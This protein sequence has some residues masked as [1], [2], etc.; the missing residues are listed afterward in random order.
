MQTRE[1]LTCTLYNMD[2]M[3]FM[4]Q[5]PDECFDL[6]VTSPP[7][8]SLRPEYSFWDTYEEYIDQLDEWFAESVRL[9]PAGRHSVWNVQQAIPSKLNGERY[10]YPLSADLIQ[11]AYR[12][13]MWLEHTVVWNKINAVCQRMFGSYPYPPTIIYTPNIEDIHIFKKPGKADLSRKTDESLITKEEWTEWALPIWNMPIS[14]NKKH[15]AT[16]PLELPKRVIRL[17]SFVG[18]TV[19]D[20]FAGLGTTG[21]ACKLLDRNFVGTE[22]KE[23]YYK[24]A[25]DNINGVQPRL[26]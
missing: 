21:V 22:L 19:F 26:L 17:H 18:D 3:E 9:I 25:R 7:Y 5:Q 2:C 13:G 20:P 12:H 1:G 23:E 15:A 14:Y 4:R 6:L 16:F 8:W 24:L 10:H 11:I